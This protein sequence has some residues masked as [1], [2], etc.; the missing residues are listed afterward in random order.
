MLAV[1]Q[2]GDGVSFEVRVTPRASKS[3]L[4]GVS[5]GALKVSL[6]APPVDG[7]ANTALCEYL[8]E[9]L[10][11]PRRAVEIT[12]GLQG[13]RKTVRVLGL[14]APTLSARLDGAKP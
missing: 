11:V 5:E 6:T 3:A 8:A 2:S 9:L 12:H 10:D 14:D 7:A 13:R 1:K 4:R